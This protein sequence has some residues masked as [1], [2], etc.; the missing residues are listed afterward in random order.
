MCWCFWYYPVIRT[1]F[2]LDTADISYM[3]YHKGMVVLYMYGL[4]VVRRTLS[5]FQQQQ[6][7]NYGLDGFG[8]RK[9]L[10]VFHFFL[11]CIIIVV[12]S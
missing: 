12:Q 10:E 11:F 7:P 1:V 3:T 8:E 9:E 5:S 2:L 6:I 4:T